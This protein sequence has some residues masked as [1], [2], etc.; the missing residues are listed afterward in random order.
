LRRYACSTA[1]VS[2]PPPVAQPPHLRPPLSQE[3]QYIEQLAPCQYRINKGFVPG[4]RVPGIFY[5]NDCLK[6]L[7]F[8]E[9]EAACQRGAHGGFL[10]AVKQIANVAALPGIVKVRDVESFS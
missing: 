1:P 2:S 3:L 9:L 10:P 8:D 4:M 7:V 6:G 5:L